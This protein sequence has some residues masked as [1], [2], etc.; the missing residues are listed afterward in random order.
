MESA[1][2]RIERARS[3][4]IGEMLDLWRSIPGLG[5]GQGDEEASLKFFMDRNSSSC[6][7]L[8]ESGR[9]IGTVMGGF[10][11]RR[12]YI[13]HLAIHPDYRGKGYGKAL[14]DH[15]TRE[16]KAL[17]APK[18][19]LFAFN[20]NQAAAGFYPSQGWERRQDIQVFSWDGNKS[21]QPLVTPIDDENV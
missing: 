2:C 6:L 8:K 3:A 11:G 16:L 17:G 15:V 18:I 13:Y 10:D 19:H 14:L 5:I 20:D 1:G 21:M 9:L 7:V 4:D 12:G